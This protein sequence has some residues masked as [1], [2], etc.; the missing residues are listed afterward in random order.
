MCRKIARYLRWLGVSTAI[1]S[2]GDYRRRLLGSQMGW[3]FFQSEETEEIRLKVAN[4]ALEDLCRFLCGG[5][6]VHIQIISIKIKVISYN[7]YI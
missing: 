1:F 2:V 3:K 6:Q 4:S 5:G 7:G